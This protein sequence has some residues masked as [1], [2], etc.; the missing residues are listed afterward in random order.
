MN[1]NG[2]RKGH[3]TINALAKLTYDTV[4]AL[5]SGNYYLSVFLELCNAFDTITH[6]L[7]CTRLHH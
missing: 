6:S 1:K 4:H 7:L 5:D 2:F 3:F